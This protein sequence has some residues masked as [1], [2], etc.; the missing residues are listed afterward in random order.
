MS[1]S[2]SKLGATLMRHPDGRETVLVNAANCGSGKDE[3]KLKHGPLV[4]D[5]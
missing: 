2:G 3:R 1:M 5:L 4:I